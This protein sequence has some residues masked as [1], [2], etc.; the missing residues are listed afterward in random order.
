MYLRLG[1][2][3]INA[4]QGKITEF[5]F[6]KNSTSSIDTQVAFY[7]AKAM[8]YLYN[9]SDAEFMQAVKIL[10]DNYEKEKKEPVKPQS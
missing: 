4:I 10:L 3:L 8:T 9:M 2:A 6:D 7:K 5:K 1:Q